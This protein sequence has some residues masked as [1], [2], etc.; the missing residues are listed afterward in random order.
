[1]LRLALRPY[2]AVLLLLCLGR[3]LLPEAWV[4]GLHRHEH[5]THEAAYA[6]DHIKGKLLIGNQHQH[7]AVEHFYDVAYQVAGPVRLPVPV[8]GRH[9]QAL[10]GAA[11]LGQAAGRPWRGVALRGPPAA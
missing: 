4:L 7:C 10:R 2:V 3:T 9:D 1:M 6:P 5:T 8:A 11:T